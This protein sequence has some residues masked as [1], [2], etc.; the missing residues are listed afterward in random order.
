LAD[1]LQ[2][3]IA[4]WNQVAHPFQWTTKSVAKVMA[5]CKLAE[6]AQDGGQPM[7]A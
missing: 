5:K 6:V 3:F 2:A 1:R 4:E 7:A